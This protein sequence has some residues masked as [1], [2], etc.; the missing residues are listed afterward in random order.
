MAF[1][2][3]DGGSFGMGRQPN[4]FAPYP[5]DEEQRLIDT[6]ILSKA[7]GGLQYAAETLDKPGRAMRGLLA[8][9]PSELL[10]LVP[11]S[12]TL[13]LTDPQQSTSGR[14]L[15]EQYGVLDKNTPG[16]DFGDVVGFGA[17]IL[18]DPLTYTGLGALTKAGKAGQA[19]GKTTKPLA[20]G[21]RAGERSLLD[22]GLP[23]GEKMGLDRIPLGTGELSAKVA[24]TVAKPFEKLRWSK[25]GKETA[26]LFDYDVGGAGS[27]LGQ[28]LHKPMVLDATAERAYQEAK[29]LL[30]TRRTLE[31]TGQLSEDHIKTMRAVGEGVE[32]IATVPP[33]FQD[34]AQVGLDLKKQMEPH[35]REAQKYGIDV[36]ELADDA[37]DYLARYHHS[38]EHNGL[39]RGFFD[40]LKRKGDLINK[41]RLKILKGIPGGTE[42]VN[43]LF[44]EPA[45]WSAPDSKT[46]GAIIEGITGPLADK[47]A[48]QI[49]NWM[50]GMDPAEHVGKRFFN[51]DPITDGIIRSYRHAKQV[52]QA[53]YSHELLKQ[54]GTPLSKIPPAEVGNYIPIR[55]VLEQAGLK[56]WSQNI[57]TKA[58]PIHAG[59]GAEPYLASQMGLPVDIG[60]QTVKTP[61]GFAKAPKVDALDNMM[62]PREIA[63][64]VLN[65]V[66]K[67]NSPEEM[68]AVL[69]LYDQGLALWK[70]GSTQMWPAFHSRNFASGMFY[71][72][73]SGA[74]GNTMETLPAAYKFLHGQ[75]LNPDLLKRMGVSSM[76]ELVAEIQATGTIK[77]GHG[78]TFDAVA[79]GPTA[80]L[81]V[82]V[83]AQ[84]PATPRTGT[85]AAKQVWDDSVS[86]IKSAKDYKETAANAFDA[87]IDAGRKMGN[88]TEDML[89]VNQYMAR[90]LQG[91]TPEAAALDVKKWLFDYGE[92]SQFEKNVMKRGLP[93]YTFMRKNTP[94]VM[95]EL[96]R[97]PGGLIAQTMRGSQQGRQD[98]GYL[99]EH[100]GET[101]AIPM[102]G[103]P[104]RFITGLGLPYESAFQT[105]K[106]APTLTKTLGRTAESLIASATPPASIGYSIA[107]GREPFFGRNLTDLYPY[108]TESPIANLLINKGLGRPVTELRRATDPRKSLLDKAVDFT[109]GAKITDVSGGL[110]RQQQLESKRVLGNILSESPRIKSFTNYYA[111]P[112]QRGALTEEEVRN[113]KLMAGLN[114]RG[115]D[116]A[117]KQKLTEQQA[118]LL[119]R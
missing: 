58:K 70:A 91:W 37:V 56:T 87:F 105:V 73:A 99:P 90:R 7:K 4:P 59:W 9:R 108:P 20:A 44:M 77:P 2:D 101:T 65:V 8:G 109:T 10:N 40:R 79:T 97:K 47:Q 119:N 22:V 117:K 25:P 41:G 85:Q 83:G 94:L 118:F 114:K 11:F 103:T 45:I 63:S 60:F 57:G 23:F 93:F 24:E 55:D 33:A 30:E 81:P 5:E 66:K 18:T 21:I 1:G 36:D 46:A 96:I 52:N 106:L 42:Q 12:D 51:A 69:G 82:G 115:R 19:A 111:D 64:D 15:L 61:G 113:L 80:D 76:D 67:W 107:S 31:K 48:E 74:S 88:F 62:V 72:Y 43:D 26:R 92:L 50:R 110:E 14:D 71:H 116:A 78:Q 75:D 39:I 95:K 6:Y 84:I 17:E 89:R 32:D 13:G 98:Q 35:V 27:Q 68:K 3:F 29:P 102:P 49:A 28:E 86:H 112:R 54:T 104:G 100:I 38:D 53:N 16:L 34:V